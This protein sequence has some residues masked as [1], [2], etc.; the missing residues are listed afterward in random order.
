VHAVI[1][2]RSA[3]YGAALARRFQFS[4]KV[5]FETVSAGEQIMPEDTRILISADR[6]GMERD[7]PELVSLARLADID[8]LLVVFPGRA[9]AT[10]EETIRLK[11][12]R[13]L[14]GP[15]RT[16]WAYKLMRRYVPDV[17]GQ[18]V[19]EIK[20]MFDE[21]MA[22][23]VEVAVDLSEKPRSSVLGLFAVLYQDE[24]YEVELTVGGRRYLSGWETYL[25][26][27]RTAVRAEPHPALYLLLPRAAGAPYEVTIKPDRQGRRY[28]DLKGA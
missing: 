20:R 21:K 15:V 16:G 23:S 28:Y 1:K 6:Q 4:K 3:T 25:D 27:V 17:Y 12:F 22:D 13:E 7:L 10:A 14:C 9:G 18:E 26:A 24:E 2:L 8:P 5:V 19:A 11:T